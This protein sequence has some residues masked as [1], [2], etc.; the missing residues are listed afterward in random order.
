MLISKQDGS[1]GLCDLIKMVL[2]GALSCDPDPVERVAC[3]FNSLYRAGFRAQ[4]P[5]K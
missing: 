5:S 2:M 4:P 1:K 3:A